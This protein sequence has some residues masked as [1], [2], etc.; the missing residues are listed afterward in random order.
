MSAPASPVSAHAASSGILLDRARVALS[1]RI[2]LHDLTL[3]LTEARI[4]IV[5]RNGSGKTTLLRL[6][7]G[8]IAPDAGRVRIDGL[9]PATDRKGMLAALGILFQNPD[10]QI[11]FPTVEEEL[12]FGLRQQGRTQQD[13]LAAARAA[14]A[15]EG[16]AH[17][18]PAP[19]SALS[20]GQRHY[21]CLMTVLLM[22]PR[23]ILLDEPFAGLD[24]P[25][26]DRLSRRL[27]ALPQR[28][29]TISHDPAAVADADR[30]LWIDAGRITADGSPAVVLAAFRAEMA[31]IG[32]RDA[33]TDLAG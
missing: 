11:L 23:T 29:V 19:T 26:Q 1:G 16:R 13:A 2:I 8:L 33:D 7:A 21:L 30:V 25:T 14:L 28:L 31:R 5:G 4:G 15:A 17:W 12:A 9:D 6:I 18:G 20:Q 22:Q 10:H 32:E 3:H 24:L 27:A